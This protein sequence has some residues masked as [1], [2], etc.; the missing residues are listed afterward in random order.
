MLAVGVAEEQGLERRLAEAL[1][2]AVLA[3]KALGQAA[4]GLLI[5]AAVAVVVQALPLAAQAAPAS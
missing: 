2:V 1:A 5:L 4:P 3:G